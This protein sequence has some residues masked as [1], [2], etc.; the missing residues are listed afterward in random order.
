MLLD[1]R[2]HEY[3][4]DIYP[5]IKKGIILDTSVFKI[6]A[7]GIVCTRFTKKK[8]PEFDEIMN[9]LDILKM[10][11]K[12]SNFFITP[13]ILTEICRHIQ[14]DYNHWKNYKEILEQIFPMIAAFEEKAVKKEEI[15]L[16]IDYKNPIVEVGDISIFVIADDYE[17]K[18]KKI[19][20]LAEDGRINNKYIQSKNVMVLNYKLNMLNQL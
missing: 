13:H 4:K 6:I 20:I 5:Y 14:H 19:A 1:L 10:N 12:W 2:V 18:K 15:L 7:D 11:N 9:F 17:D 3:D 16:L 8:S